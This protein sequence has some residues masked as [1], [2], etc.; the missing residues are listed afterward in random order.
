MLFGGRERLKAASGDTWEW[1]G[2]SWQRIDVSGPTARDHHATAWDPVAGRVVL[3]GGFDG[4]G[5]T[6][7]TWAWNGRQWTRLANDG[8]PPRATHGLAFDGRRG[9]LL[10]FAGLYLGG[11]YGDTWERHEGGWSRI[12]PVFAPTLDHHAMAFDGARREIIAF[13]GKNYRFTFQNRTRVSR[14]M[15]GR[16]RQPKAHLRG[17]TPGWFTTPVSSASSSTADAVLAT[18]HWVISGSGRKEMG[19]S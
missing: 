6:A 17:S 10:L 12:G 7:D 13:G 11:L 5:V 16:R 1:D 9:R 14:M 19:P 4:S 15:R 3:F 2:A 8:P 18:R